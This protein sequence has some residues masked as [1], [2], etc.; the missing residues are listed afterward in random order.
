MA[1]KVIKISEKNY[2]WLVKETA[3]LS[4]ES[5]KKATFN[6]VVE[7]LRKSKLQNQQRRILELAGSWNDVSDETLAEITKDGREGWQSWQK[8]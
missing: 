8:K 3:A 1:D 5:G 4:Y 7:R 2:S 6:D